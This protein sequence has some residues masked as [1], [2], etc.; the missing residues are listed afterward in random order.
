MAATSHSA[1]CPPLPEPVRVSQRAESPPARRSLNAPNPDPNPPRFALAIEAQCL[2]LPKPGRLRC[3]DVA[4]GVDRTWWL[5]DGATGVI[6]PDNPCDS[7][8]FAETIQAAFLAQLARAPQT[9]LDELIR[10]ALDA[11]QTQF[12]QLAP[13]AIRAHPPWWPSSTLVLV[14][15]EPAPTASAAACATLDARL[16]GDSELAV[17]GLDGQVRRLRD[18][19]HTQFCAGFYGPVLDALRAGAGYDSPRFQNA[20]AAAVT[21]ERAHRNQA[22]SYAILSPEAWSGAP[23]CDGLTAR[24]PLYPGDRIV[25]LSDGAARGFAVFGLASAD[26]SLRDL[27]TGNLWAQ[28]QAIRAAEHADP[29]GQA[30]PRGTCH[31]DATVLRL[32]PQTA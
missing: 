24:L 27:A 26:A 19:R 25:L 29:Q 23:E 3:E 22:D 8:W 11:A 28:L 20:L 2:R 14:R 18:D 21:H 7:G 31:D 30:F 13:Q 32:T 10:C 4:G 1:T 12:A 16:L 6:A 9:S 5:M 17:V 15:I